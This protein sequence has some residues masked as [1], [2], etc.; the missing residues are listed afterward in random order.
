MIATTEKLYGPYRWGRYDILVLPP[1]FPFGG[2]ENPRMTFATPTVHRR[3][4]E[5]GLAGR[6]RARAFVV[7]QPRHQCGVEAHLAQRRLHHLRREPHHR[8]GVRQ[9]AGRRGSSSS[10]R[11]E[12]RRRGRRD[13]QA[14]SA[15]GAE[16]RRPRS[17]TMRGSDV[18]YTR[19]RGSC[20]RSKRA[21][22]ATCSMP[23]CAATSTTSRSRAS[24]PS[25]CSST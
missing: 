9:G 1:R 3:R 22:A 12:L 2:M 13:A 25:R 11:D 14:R 7:G 10:R 15:A 23:T 24:P 19:A 18:A 20:A 5:P 17:P 6:A 8:G 16:L 21:S 4:Q